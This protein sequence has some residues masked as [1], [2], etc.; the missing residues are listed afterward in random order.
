M[1]IYLP[2]DPRSKALAQFGASL[3][4]SAGQALSAKTLKS[5]FQDVIDAGGSPLT[6]MQ[7][8]MPYDPELAD[9]L[10][11]QE[12]QRIGDDY[13]RQTIRKEL[14]ID[15]PDNVSGSLALGAAKI[16]MDEQSRK[17]EEAATQQKTALEWYKL[18]NPPE[19]KPTVKVTP[20][21]K[22]KSGYAY[23]DIMSGRELAEAPKPTS[24]VSINS[25]KPASAQER[26]DIA[27]ARASLDS[28]TNL[29]SLFD[30]AYVGPLA[31]RV[32]KVRDIFGGNP[33]AQS[34]FNAATS[35]F[36]N[37]IIKQITGAQMSE[38]EAKRIMKQIPEVT[39]PPT[40]WQAKAKQSIDNIKRM[41]S[42]RLEILRQSGLKVPESKTT[43]SVKSM[44][45]DELERA[46]RGE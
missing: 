38:P 32:G 27:D 31:G 16:H 41:E 29:Q 20:S 8:I 6:A 35:A 18:L 28:L 9:K 1:P 4:Q 5:M 11:D 36:K 34:E 7:R 30:A 17:A 15:V 44:S 14:G 23:T 21:N 33:Q 37:S 24:L 43:I 45:D 46:L 25:E 22:F 10:G 12:S 26:T 40:V 19:A 39:D 13:L 3:G 42:R 2:E